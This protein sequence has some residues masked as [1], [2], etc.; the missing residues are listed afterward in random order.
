MISRAASVALA[1]IAAAVVYTI[2]QITYE[3]ER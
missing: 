2:T 1:V 3:G